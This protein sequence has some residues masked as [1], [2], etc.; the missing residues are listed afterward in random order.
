MA[1]ITAATLG[2]VLLSGCYQAHSDDNLR[3]VP[4]TNNPNLIPQGGSSQMTAFGY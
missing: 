1:M 4:V 2:T 3:E